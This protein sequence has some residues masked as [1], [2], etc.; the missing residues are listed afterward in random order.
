MATDKSRVDGP[1]MGTDEPEDADIKGAEEV[2]G[3]PAAARTVLTSEPKREPDKTSYPTG[4]EAHPEDPPVRAARPDTP[5]V[6]SLGTGAGAHVPPD[7]DDYTPE[8]RPR[9]LPGQPDDQE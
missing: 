1:D 6:D 9:D 8:G 4:G 7:L 2:T 3:A 5:I